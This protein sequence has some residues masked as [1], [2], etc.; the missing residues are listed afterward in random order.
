[1]FILLQ[2]CWLDF[3]EDKITWQLS[4]GVMIFEFNL[5]DF[6]TSHTNFKIRRSSRKL[7]KSFFVFVFFVDIQPYCF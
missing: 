1:M 7:P 2:D 5:I 6:Y 3:L 4:V